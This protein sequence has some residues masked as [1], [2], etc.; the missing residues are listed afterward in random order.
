MSRCPKC[1]TLADSFPRDEM[2]ICIDGH[3]TYLRDGK[4]RQA[5]LATEQPAKRQPSRRSEGVRLSRERFGW[6]GRRNWA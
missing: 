4:W 3:T 6:Q 2:I 5:E 1:G